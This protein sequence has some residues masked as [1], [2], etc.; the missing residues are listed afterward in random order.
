MNYRLKKEARQFFDN[1]KTD[2]KPLQ[3][4]ESLGVHKNLLEEVERVYVTYGKKVS[5]FSRDLKSYDYTPKKAVIHFDLHIDCC[6][7]EDYRNFDEVALID[8][9]TKTIKS[10]VK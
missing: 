5:E 4:W 8:A 6:E 3:T 10:H 9:I 1:M 7:E 2:V